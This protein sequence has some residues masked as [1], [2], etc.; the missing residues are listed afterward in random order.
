M[1]L[2]QLIRLFGTIFEARTAV[3]C[4]DDQNE[5]LS[6]H[7]RSKAVARLSSKHAV[8]CRDDWLVCLSRHARDCRLG[9]FRVTPSRV[10]TMSAPAVATRDSPVFTEC[11][12]FS[13]VCFNLLFRQGVFRVSLCR[14]RCF[15]SFFHFCQP[16]SLLTPGLYRLLKSLSFNFVLSD[17]S[18]EHL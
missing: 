14:W 3:A 11:Y 12:L 16:F 5:S 1:A 7:A 13:R 4:R 8:V 18:P 2:E 17:F 9:V 15:E 6:R 10:A